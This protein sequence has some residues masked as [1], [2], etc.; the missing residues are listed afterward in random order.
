MQNAPAALP[1]PVEPQ[2]TLAEEVVLL[3]LDAPRGRVREAVALAGRAHDAGPH[4]YRAAVH[5]LH[6]RRL[7]ERTG[8]S[9]KHRAPA[10]A[11]LPERRKRVVAVIRRAASP[12]AADAELLVLLAD[13]RALSLGRE[14]R[15]RARMRIASIREGGETPPVVEILRVRIGLSSMSGLAGRSCP[16][17]ET[18]VMRTSIRASRQACGRRARRTAR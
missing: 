11:K 16:P 4:D 12:I 3:S 14:D 10:D 17:V 5:S 1:A 15:L 13:C 2:L 9:G 18:C 6:G 7:L 8:A